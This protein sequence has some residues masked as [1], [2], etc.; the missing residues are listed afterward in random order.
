MNTRV[1]GIVIVF[2]IVAVAVA[3]SETESEVKPTTM[4]SRLKLGQQVRVLTDNGGFNIEIP[5]DQY[6][7]SFE[8]RK[9]TPKYVTSKITEIAALTG[10]ASTV[11]VQSHQTA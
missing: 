7:K 9:N 4:M 1:L 8:R 10:Q 11:G 2:G 6:I 5:N 3:R